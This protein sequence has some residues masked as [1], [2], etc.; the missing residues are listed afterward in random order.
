MDIIGIN[1]RQNSEIPLYIQLYDF[2]KSQIQNGNLKSNSKLPSKRKLSKYL[3]ISQ[4]TVEAAYGQL[5]TEGYITSIPKKGYYVSELQGIIKINTSN[6][7]NSNKKSAKKKYKYEFF[8]VE[9]ILKV[10]LIQRGEK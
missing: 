8:Q 6:I 7:T 10:F 2:I 3:D 9:W 4:N 5:I 1:L